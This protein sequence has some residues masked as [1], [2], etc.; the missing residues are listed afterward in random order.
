MK[1]G[2]GNWV[3]MFG[4]FIVGMAV[5]VMATTPVWVGSEVNYTV[6]KELTI[7]II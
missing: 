2:K 1:A 5:L 7:I 6:V 3:L 4:L